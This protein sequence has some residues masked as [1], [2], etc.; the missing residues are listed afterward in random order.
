MD[1]AITAIKC[2]IQIDD[3]T[4][5][6]GQPTA[7][8]FKAVRDAGFEAVVN[9][10]P[11]EQDNALKNEDALIRDLGMEYHYIPVVWTAPQPKDFAAFCEVMQKLEGKKIFVHCAMNMRVTAFYSSYAM[12]H[13]GWSRD[14]ADALVARIWEAYKGFKMDE[15][16][17]SF[18]ALIRK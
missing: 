3:R 9:L 7:E 1:A 13:L 8:Q 2:F 4:G 11:S 15:T 18:I 16:W 14:Q 12:K 17:R 6:A 10:L 5:C